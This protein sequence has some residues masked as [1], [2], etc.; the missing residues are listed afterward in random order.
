MN[1]IYVIP[2]T[3][4]PP[5]KMH[6]WLIEKAAEMFPRETIHIVCSINPEKKPWFA[7]EECKIMWEESFDLPSNVKVTTL[8]EMLTVDF[9]YSKVIMIRGVRNSKESFEEEADVMLLNAEKYGITNFIHIVGNEKYAHI[10]SSKVRELAAELRLEE[11]SEYV[12]PLVISRLLEKVLEIKNLFLV[13]GKSGSG[14]STYL[15]MLVNENSQ[16]VHINTDE[17]NK[18]LRPLLEE[19]F[20]NQ[21]LVQIAIEKEEEFLEIIRIPWINLLK[22]AL[23]NLPKDSN[24]YVEIPYGLQDTKRFWNYLGGKVIYIGPKENE[25]RI[26]E[27][28][29]KKRGTEYLL[30]LAQTIPGWNGTMEL[31]N[32][33]N[34]RLM[35]INTGGNLKNLKT[36]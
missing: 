34:L 9:D 30:P 14:K 24:A 26:I 31:A 11:L 16:N 10:S 28:R 18:K 15:K 1:Y 8:G 33:Y 6:N 36:Y 19:R 13:I 4:S 22:K 17:F 2:G 32:K 25:E 3:Y 7:P 12:P 29:N 27:K 5:T 20:P 21:N 23:Q 35:Q